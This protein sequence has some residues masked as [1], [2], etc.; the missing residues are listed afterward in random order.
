MAAEKRLGC[1]A[2][3]F[4]NPPGLA[5][6][7]SIVGKKEGEGPLAMSFDSVSTDTT[8]GEKSWEKAESRMQNEALSRALAK[9]TL[10]AGDLDFVFAGDLLNQCI[11]SNFALKDSDIPFFGLYG[12]CSTMA[13][14]IT[15]A[16]MAIDGGY[17]GRAAAITSSHFCSAERQYRMPLEYGGQRPPSSQWTVTGAGCVILDAAGSSPYLTHAAIGRMVDAGIR[18][19][20]NMGAAM[21]PA[22]YDT[23]SRM[24]SDLG[25]RPGD[26]DMILTGDLGSLG[27]AL[28]CELFA[29]DGVDINPVHRDCGVMIYDLQRQD[30][31]C[32]GSGCG[33]LASLLCGH[34]LNGMR[35]G[36][37]NRV[38]FAGT[39][40]LLSP[41]SANQ[42]QTIPCI[43]H[44]AI[45]SNTK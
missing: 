11:S 19:S 41:V 42:G 29:R 28:L 25:A 23:I 35:E 40:A 27:S 14:A 9:A 38:L 3:R 26:F 8:F 10:S 37:W 39:G 12:A 24:L 21:A 33:C 36:K 4:A 6:C 13:E 34:I 5:A 17:A 18:D 7:A 15:L 2:I 44:A 45:F 30:V 22:A 32:G 16:A 1:A 31:H 20:N 43:A